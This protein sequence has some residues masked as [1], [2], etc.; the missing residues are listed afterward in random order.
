MKVLNILTSKFD[1]DG[2]SNS[3]FGYYRNFD[4][5]KVDM[6]FVAPN[7][8]EDKK[9]EIEKNNNRVYIIKD[10]KS[11]P[12]KYMRELKKII[13]ENDYDIVQ[14]HGSSAI[15]FLEMLAAKRAGCKIRIA[16]SRNT[17]ASHKILDFIFRPIFYSTYTT[18]FACGEEAGKWLFHDRPFYIINNGK[19]ANEFMYKEEVRNKI[20]KEWDLDGKIVLGH[21]GTFNYQKNHDFLIDI[22]Y[23]LKKLNHQNYKLV[24]LGD[25][26]LQEDIREKVSKL[27]LDRDVIFVGRTKD[28]SQWLQAMDIMVFPSRFEGFPNVLIEWQMAALPCYISDI[29]T[30]DVAVTDLVHFLSIDELPKKWAEEIS[31]TE[32]I[33]RNLI[34]DKV[35]SEIKKNGYD[36]KENAKK[37]ENIYFNLI[38]GQEKV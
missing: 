30:K 15:L 34:K 20:R 21:V 3:V 17:K 24:L 26:K 33:D 32:I 36:I 38:Q 37:L 25:G 29:I 4:K 14:A 13:E 11:K 6:D 2:I 10:R 28:V 1:M 16:H 7:I 12:F 9:K 5:T 27:K 23:E 19:D 35:I 8:S 31:K 22:F 18:G